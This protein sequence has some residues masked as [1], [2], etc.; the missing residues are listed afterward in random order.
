[1]VGISALQ[2]A[3]PAVE[4]LLDGIRASLPPGS[5]TLGPA[6]ISF[7]YPWL[8][9]SAGRAVLDDVAAALAREA[10]FDV[11]LAGPRRFATEPGGPIT[12]WLAPHPAAAIHA[13]SWVIGDAA[14]HDVE[15]FT[16]HCSLVRFEPGI[17]PAPVERLLTP[18]VPLRARLE[19]VEFR[20]RDEHGWQIERTLPLGHGGL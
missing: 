18:Q 5:T 1:M 13:L 2:L 6:H 3:V 11:E 16:P 17:D 19:T 20:V 14:G 12:V 10:P 15:N 9:P 8:E 7:G 4:P